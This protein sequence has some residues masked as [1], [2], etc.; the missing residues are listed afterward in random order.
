MAQ[1][2][3]RRVHRFTPG[4][5]FARARQ[6]EALTGIG[7]TRHLCDERT[8]RICDRMPTSMMGSSA[9]LV[10]STFRWR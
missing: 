5:L 2:I 8:W 4:E 7:G 6:A 10:T 3:T 1:A 9:A